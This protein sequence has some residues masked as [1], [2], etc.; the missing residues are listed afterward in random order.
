[1]WPLLGNTHYSKGYKRE[2]TTSREPHWIR[3]RYTPPSD[4]DRLVTRCVILQ[5]YH[6]IEALSR[7][8]LVKMRSDWLS[9]CVSLLFFKK[10]VVFFYRSL[11]CLKELY[12]AVSHFF[13]TLIKRFWSPPN[14][15]VTYVF[16]A[17]F[18][19]NAKT[20]ENAS[21]SSKER[22]WT[23]W[24]SLDIWACP[25]HWGKKM[26]VTA[27][28]LKFYQVDLDRNEKKNLSTRTKPNKPVFG[29]TSADVFSINNLEKSFSLLTLLVSRSTLQTKLLKQLLYFWISMNVW[30]FLKSINTFQIT[31]FTVYNA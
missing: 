19:I 25:I 3:T 14:S 10:D 29:W 13:H 12:K 9:W 31:L 28:D 7:N 27:S 30:F 15:C 5:V 18:N 2:I 26:F 24:F 1:M 8:W 17:K 21:N 6:H 22:I 20:Q 11:R 23:H 16:G 4:S